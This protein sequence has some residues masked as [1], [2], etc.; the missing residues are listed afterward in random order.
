MKEGKHKLIITL[1]DRLGAFTSYD[2][3]LWVKAAPVF[4][5]ETIIEEEK[6]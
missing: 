6:I 3:T 2:I 1:R 5:F 4:N